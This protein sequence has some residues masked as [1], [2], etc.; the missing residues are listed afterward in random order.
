MTRGTRRD[1]YVATH[2]AFFR[3]NGATGLRGREGSGARAIRVPKYVPDSP[4]LS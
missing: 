1:A 4:N 3:V 2:R